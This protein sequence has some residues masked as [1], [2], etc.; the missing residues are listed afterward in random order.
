M[1]AGP[2]AA[3][4]LMASPGNRLPKTTIYLLL[5]TRKAVADAVIEKI[6]ADA[7]RSRYSKRMN[8]DT[9]VRSGPE[10]MLSSSASWAASH[11]P[12]PGSRADRLTPLVR[13][14]RGGL[15]GDHLSHGFPRTSGT[16]R[17]PPAPAAPARQARIPGGRRSGSAAR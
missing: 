14:K 9:V 7:G 13:V 3:S 11:R 16:G 6:A 1:I 17:R 8:S 12:R 15:F 5:A 4:S 10:V 2:P